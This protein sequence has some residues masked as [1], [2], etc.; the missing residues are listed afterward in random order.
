[1]PSRIPLRELETIFLD[2]GNTL[3]SIDFARVANACEAHGI[4]TTQEE[5]RRAEA[6]VRPQTSQ[7]AHERGG[8]E[9]S[10]LFAAMLNSVLD[11]VEGAQGLRPEERSHAA[12]A[13]SAELREPGASDR[14]WC[15]ILPGTEDA[16]TRMQAL[17]LDLVVVSNSDGT[18]ARGLNN[19]GLGP[20]FSHMVDSHLVGSEKPD[21]EIFRVAMERSQAKPETTL[22][23][24]DIYHADV[25]GARP[26]GIHTL[27][28]DPWSD[29]GE[30]DCAVLPDLQALA[31]LL[32]EA[33]R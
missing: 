31:S 1:M 6:R 14:L 8:T 9:A 17:G 24:G 21:P 16:L 30:M 12:H 20:F 25:M 18:V 10:D 15:S 7:R 29:W 4:A 33:R 13:L 28:L 22:H 23:V 2:A 27:L 26:L 3:V 5:L 32:E 11:V 19:I